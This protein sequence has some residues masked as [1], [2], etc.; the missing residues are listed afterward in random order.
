MSE[1]R[2]EV[3]QVLN[4][5]YGKA[6]QIIDDETLPL[7]LLGVRLGLE[8]ALKASACSVC[9][10][11]RPVEPYDGPERWI[12][13]RESWSHNDWACQSADIRAIDP[14]A[15]LKRGAE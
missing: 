3:N 9:R 8:A 5:L 10:E 1:Y 2:D 15:V 6:E 4:A 12:H 7:I 11:G 13:R 14:A